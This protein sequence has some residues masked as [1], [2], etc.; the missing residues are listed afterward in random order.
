MVYL[1]PYWIETWVITGFVM[2]YLA[3]HVLM[4][5][6]TCAAAMKFCSPTVAATQFTLYMAI[7]NLGSS[8]GG[9]LVAPIEAL[10]GYVGLLLAITL[11]CFLGILFVWLNKSHKLA[12]ALQVAT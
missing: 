4:L 3:S 6:T 12:P 5:V 9:L 1:Q 2:C 7:A 10:G 11:T 8:F